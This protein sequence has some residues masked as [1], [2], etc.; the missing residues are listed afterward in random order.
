MSFEK[1]IK[2]GNRLCDVSSH[3]FNLTYVQYNAAYS[4]SQE[5]SITPCR[6]NLNDR[7]EIACELDYPVN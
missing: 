1:R 7:Q 5:S 4:A 2:N 3:M 6:L